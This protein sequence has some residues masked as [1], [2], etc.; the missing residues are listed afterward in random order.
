[1]SFSFIKPNVIYFYVFY[2]LLFI[3][4]VGVYFIF[5]LFLQTLDEVAACANCRM[6]F[7]SISVSLGFYECSLQGKSAFCLTSGATK[8]YNVSRP[9]LISRIN[10]SIINKI[11]FKCGIFLAAERVETQQQRGV[12]L[13]TAAA[14]ARRAVAPPSVAADSR[15]RSPV[16]CWR[17]VWGG[18]F[19][20]TRVLGQRTRPATPYRYSRLTLQH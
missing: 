8:T 20:G 12:S 11:G 6:A 10:I 13:P 3:L 4:L 2:S 15:F 17:N 14:T 1:M 18:F 19:R 5:I 7:W 9:N 16:G